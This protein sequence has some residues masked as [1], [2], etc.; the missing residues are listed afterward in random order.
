MGIGT[1]E[2]LGKTV[3]WKCWAYEPSFWPLP[4]VGLGIDELG[5]CFQKQPPQKGVHN[6]N[7]TPEHMG[8]SI[9]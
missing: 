3:F 5:T 1:V 9:F 4:C 8:L 2:R 6:L 7:N